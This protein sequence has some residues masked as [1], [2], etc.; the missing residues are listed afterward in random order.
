[1]DGTHH[2][3]PVLRKYSIRTRNQWIAST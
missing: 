3:T 1:M 2:A